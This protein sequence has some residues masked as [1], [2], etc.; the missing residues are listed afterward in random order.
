MADYN[1]NMLPVGTMLHGRYRIEKYLASGGFGNTYL[2]HD[3]LFDEP[4]A[5]KEFFMRSVSS[6][7][8][9]SLTVSVSNPSNRTSFN[10]HLDKFRKE[11][12]RVRKLRNDHI[13]KVHDLFDEFGTS[14]YVMD[15]VEGES[16]SA[17]MKHRG[18]PFDESTVLGFLDQVLDA[19]TETHRH[20][21]WHLDIKPGNLMMDADGKLTLI[22]FGASKL[23]DATGD[24]STSSMM[25]YTPGY[26]PI[27]QMEQRLEAIGAHTDFYAL[28]A[29]LYNLL[30]SQNPPER[31]LI[32]DYG[33]DAF[34]YPAATS[35][36]MRNL[37][38]YMMQPLR[39]HRP[40][41]IQQ[42]RQFIAANNLKPA[43]LLDTDDVVL[44]TDALEPAPQPVPAPA[45]KP[46]PVPAPALKPEPAPAPKPAPSPMPEP[47]P[48]PAQAPKPALAPP[49]VPTPTPAP[50]PEPTPQ[51]VPEPIPAPKSVPVSAPAPAHKPEPIPVSAPEPAP[52]PEP[53]PVPAPVPKPQPAPIKEQF[54]QE[55]VKNVDD[56][57]KASSKSQ[58]IPPTASVGTDKSNKAQPQRGTTKD[59]KPSQEQSERKSRKF[60]IAGSI[61]AALVILAAVVTFSLKTGN[62]DADTPATTQVD[63]IAADSVNTAHQQVAAKPAKQQ[64]ASTKKTSTRTEKAAS[65]TSKQR[66]KSQTP[67]SRDA[68]PSAKTQGEAT[69]SSS[70]QAAT[71][72]QHNERTRHVPSSMDN[73]S[74]SNEQRTRHV[75]NM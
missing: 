39:R 23:T 31:S 68:Q 3:T 66:T 52:K 21:I 50:I 41:N 24:H 10:S 7:D 33:D 37:I 26:A 20:S 74:N 67:T 18:T 4:V 60:A 32:D 38:R 28:G 65:S 57:T 42:L 64:T 22:D 13:V 11:A 69:I 34:Q 70:T 63:T 58:P 16:L 71:K 75:P 1:E 8:T 6:R 36:A 14:Y 45:P 12:K 19:L 53:V 17:N 55:P 46:E 15:Y 44:V 54:Q 51:A 35:P 49:S 61:A 25:A 27:E 48:V 30:T 47:M 43:A 59:E 72:T 9:Q 2:A 62:S 40:Q 5:V 29:T 56:I 73:S